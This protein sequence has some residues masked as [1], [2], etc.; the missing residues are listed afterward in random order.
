MLREPAASVKLSKDQKHPHGP[1]KKLPERTAYQNG[2]HV[3]TANL[4]AQR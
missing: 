2:Q 1:K 3:S 4:I